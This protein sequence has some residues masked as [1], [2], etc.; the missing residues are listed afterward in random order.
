MKSEFRFIKVDDILDSADSVPRGEN[1]LFQRKGSSW[2]LF[3]HV[4][5]FAGDAGVQV[6]W[7]RK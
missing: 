6:S 7:K 2:L 5:D 4:A 3:S 1:I